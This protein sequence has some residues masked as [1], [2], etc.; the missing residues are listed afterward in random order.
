MKQKTILALTALVLVFSLA[1]AAQGEVFKDE[2]IYARL[3]ALGKAEAVYVV[4]AFE[5]DL[6]AAVT[7]YGA[8]IEALP[9]GEADGF[10]Y[11]DGET[12]FTMRPGRFS[13]EG[14]AADTALP[15]DIRLGFTLDG[16]PME[17]AQLS[18][19]EGHLEG[20]L[21]VSVNEALSEYAN[22]LSLQITLGLDGDKARNIQSDKATLAVAGGKRTLSF[23]ILP[24]QGADYAFS[25][26]VTDFAMPGF[27]AAGVRMGMDEEMYQNMASAALQGSPLQGAV[28]GMMDNF[29]AGM[30]GQQ[31]RSFMDARNAVR[32]VQFVLMGPDVPQRKAEIAQAP[33]EQ[34]QSL[35][36]RLKGI[37]GL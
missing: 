14:R 31:A 22:G 30:Q 36:E 7:D 5:S 28:A 21:K 29:L 19:A 32:S 20:S 26:D 25:A 13:Y 27:Q 10:A 4:N 2:I 3:D 18:G 24:G 34:P 11:K 6:E 23:V 12:A 33:D 9:L 8:Y 1:A 16:V 17:A 15:W 37:F 35:M